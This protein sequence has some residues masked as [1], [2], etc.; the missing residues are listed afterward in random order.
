MSLAEFWRLNGGAGLVPFW[1]Y[2]YNFKI[3]HKNIFVFFLQILNSLWT[4]FF[5]TVLLTKPKTIQHIL[6]L[7]LNEVHLHEDK[8][9]AVN[10]RRKSS[11]PI[12]VVSVG[13][14]NVSMRRPRR[15]RTMTRRRRR[16]SLLTS[17]RKTPTRK[18]VAVARKQM[19][20]PL[21]WRPSSMTSF[22]V[23]NKW[24][25]NRHIQGTIWI[26]NNNPRPPTSGT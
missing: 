4:F 11:H 1:L 8:A 7:F 21:P 22:N 12:I 14:T 3:F 5:P 18:K 19:K 6:T 9:T 17:L 26:K 25:Q 13:A 16:R 10:S 23:E 2:K 20:W 24:T 15:K